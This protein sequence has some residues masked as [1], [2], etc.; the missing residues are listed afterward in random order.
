MTS[1]S[2]L[3]ILPA[4]FW[5]SHGF[6]EW[7]AEGMVGLQEKLISGSSSLRPSG[8]EFRGAIP[9]YHEL[10]LPYWKVFA[11]T[12]GQ[13]DTFRVDNVQLPHILWQAI[14]PKINGIKSLYLED[15]KLGTEDFFSLAQFL[16]V[17]TTLEE[18]SFEGPDS[19]LAD[20]QAAKA[21]GLAMKNHPSLQKVNAIYME[22]GGNYHLDKPTPEI[23]KEFIDGCENCVEMHI[24]SRCG[25]DD[26]CAPAYGALVK[27][28]K[29]LT[30][31][32][33]FWEY[34]T[35][36]GVEEITRGVY[37]T[38]TL[39]DIVDSNHKC[40]IYTSE[41]QNEDPNKMLQPR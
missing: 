31:L 8:I 32:C 35:D 25:M 17:N 16:S 33:L 12:P 18:L 11:N 4:S 27:R 36:D 15:N 26:A 9:A 38:T 30:S 23:A 28:N 19:D 6:N 21:L 10:A 1:E 39:N 24:I 20:L 37:D 2:P 29:K 14:T 7:D 13:L 3:E 22:I 41:M 40:I 5:K 34:F